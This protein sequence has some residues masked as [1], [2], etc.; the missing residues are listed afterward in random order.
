MDGD[1]DKG[2]E[3]KREGQI[4]PKQSRRVARGPTEGGEEGGSMAAFQ[5]EVVNTEAAGVGKTKF[6]M[7]HRGQDDEEAAD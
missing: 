2:G 4:V 5:D 7:D 3:G 1:F 6:G